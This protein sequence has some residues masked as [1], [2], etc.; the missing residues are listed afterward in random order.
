ML[1]YKLT[2]PAL[3]RTASPLNKLDAPIV[4]KKISPS[5]LEEIFFTTIGASSLFSGDAVR[6]NAGTVNLYDNIVTNHAVGLSRFGGSVTED[7]NLFY[8]NSLNKSG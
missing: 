8:G 4:V 7:Y 6:I 3:M 5:G 2:V 1:S